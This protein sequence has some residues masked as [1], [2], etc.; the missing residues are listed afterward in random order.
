MTHLNDKTNQQITKSY[1]KP[2]DNG[3]FE[4]DMDELERKA[5]SSLKSPSDRGIREISGSTPDP[6]SDDD[7]LENAH[8]MGIAP[9]ADFENPTEL[10]LAKDIEEAEKL[11]RDS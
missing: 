5:N 8:A 1:D 10:N 11:R 4:Q 6:E 9:N 3:T 7:V 2:V